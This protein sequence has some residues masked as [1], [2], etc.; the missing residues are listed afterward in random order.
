MRKIQLSRNKYTIVDDKDFLL[1]EKFVWICSSAGYAVRHLTD[2]VG[3]KKT[4]LM[5]RQILNAPKKM[6]IDHVNNDRL[7]NR[8]ENL[9]FC[10]HWENTCNRKISLNNKSG[11]KGVSWDKKARKWRTTIQSKY[12]SMYLGC[13]SSKIEAAGVYNQ[14]AREL[15]GDFACLN[16]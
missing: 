4:I 16:I 6:E 9:R 15:F 8:R 3:N 1:L 5:H 12:K 2:C 10:S 13:Y 14:Y 11:Y 7:D